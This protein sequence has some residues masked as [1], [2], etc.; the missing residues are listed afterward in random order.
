M[1]FK[2]MKAEDKIGD[3][4]IVDVRHNNGHKISV[5]FDRVFFPFGK[6]KNNTLKFDCIDLKTNEKTQ[7][8]IELMKDLNREAQVY[9]DKSIFNPVK[10]KPKYDLSV[11]GHVNFSQKKLIT[12]VGVD[13]GLPIP[14]TELKGYQASVTL[15]FSSF[16]LVND[17]IFGKWKYE[18]ITVFR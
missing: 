3:F 10:H 11:T 6:N 9:F 12:K 2:F 7:R 4:D 13:K 8:A 1:R 18:N 16:W 14:V 5:T 15:T 17:A